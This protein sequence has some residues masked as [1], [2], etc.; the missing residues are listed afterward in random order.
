MLFPPIP[1]YTLVNPNL[2]Y[3]ILDNKRSFI[4]STVE[5][6]KTRWFVSVMFVIDGL[7]SLAIWNPFYDFLV[8]FIEGL[9]NIDFDHHSMCM[10]RTG[11]ALCS[12]DSIRLSYSKTVINNS[13][14]CNMR[15]SELTCSKLSEKCVFDAQLRKQSYSHYKIQAV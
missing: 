12:V 5:P 9:R 6:L 2:P 10:G 8:R 3:H 15:S 14:Q 4:I 7:A 11:K 1:I 13:F